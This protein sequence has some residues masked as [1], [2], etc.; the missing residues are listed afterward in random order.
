MTE[1]KTLPKESNGCFTLAIILGC[2]T[3]ALPFLFCGGVFFVFQLAKE[4]DRKE[5]A[6]MTSEQRLKQ[7]KKKALEADLL[8]LKIESRRFI[9]SRLKAPKTAQIELDGGPL[10]NGLVVLFD[11][12]VTSQNSFG[13]NLTKP[14]SM[15]YARKNTA[16]KFEQ[17]Y[18]KFED[19]RVILNEELWEFVK[20]T[21]KTN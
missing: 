4:T 3:I 20:S 8:R 6:S 19:K 12:T 18:F 10:N 2:T 7:D 11:G 9:A 16:S 15:A 5:L 21:T 1:P 14:V 13:A 17:L